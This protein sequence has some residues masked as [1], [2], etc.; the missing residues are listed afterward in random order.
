MARSLNYVP[1]VPTPQEELTAASLENAE[2]LLEG[3]R[4]LRALHEHGVLDMLNRVVRGGSGL[5]GQTLHTLEGVGGTVLIRNLLEVGR[6]LTELDPQ[7]VGTLGRAL[8]A[9]VNEGARRVAQGERVGLPELLGLLRDPDIQVALT[10]LFGTLKGFGHALRT[11]D[12]QRQEP[13]EERRTSGER[14]L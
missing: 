4:L 1:P 10:A 8:N 2:A 5:T 7:S 3:L 6:T 12:A 11:A 13:T 14:P 9:G